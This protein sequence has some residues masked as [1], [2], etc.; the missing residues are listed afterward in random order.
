MIEYKAPKHIPRDHDLLVLRGVVTREERISEGLSNRYRRLSKEG[1][2][3][4]LAYMLRYR[5]E[6]FGE[7]AR[8][9]MIMVAAKTRMITE[10]W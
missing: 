7:E 4:E 10:V 1:M 2:G 3:T 8:E 6:R 5:S 9:E